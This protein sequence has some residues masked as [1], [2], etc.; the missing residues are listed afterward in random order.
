MQHMNYKVWVVIY[1]PST[2][3][4]GEE[5]GG[6]VELYTQCMLIVALTIWRDINLCRE[7]CDVDFKPVLYWVEDLGICLIWHKGHRQS[8]G[9]KPSSTSNL[10]TL[11]TMKPGSIPELVHWLYVDRCL[12]S[13]ACHSWWRCWLSLCP[14]PVQ[15]GLWPPWYVCWSFW[16]PGTW[17][18]WGER[19]GRWGVTPINS[20]AFSHLSSWGIPRWMQMAG[21]FCSTSNW[22]RAIH[23]CTDFTKMITYTQ[24][25]PP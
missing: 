15:T 5:E 11:K 3:E 7:D 24:E 4:K 12:N 19:G 1:I 20:K 18:T 10:L 21:K 14:C 13:Q 25:T 6:I 22:A 8:F 9:T 17:P 16:M 2:A 23:R